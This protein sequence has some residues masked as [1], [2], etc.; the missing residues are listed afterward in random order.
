MKKLVIF[1]LDGTL[2]NTILDLSV[3]VDYALSLKGLE[4]FSYS[5]YM[6]MVGHGITNLV[7]SALTA[8]LG[9][10]PEQGMLDESVKAFTD[11]YVS[12]IDIN[13]KPFDGMPELLRELNSRGVKMAVASNKFHEG[14]MKLVGEFFPEI[15][16]VAVMGN[17]PELPLKPDA[18]VVNLILAKAGLDKEDAILVGDS[19]TDIKTAVNAGIESIG[20]EWGYRPADTLV[21]AGAGRLAATVADLR[22]MLL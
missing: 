18:E 6:T 17:S 10:E 8:R 13:T 20:V 19:S 4:G 22:A 9:Q 16:F 12:H 14:T 21:D 3:A 11:Y 2:L 7:K 15:P 1:D 5:E